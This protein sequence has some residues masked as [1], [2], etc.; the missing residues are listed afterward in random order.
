[1]EQLTLRDLTGYWEFHNRTEN[2]SADTVR[3]CNDALATLE[4]YLVGAGMSTLIA[5]IGEPE[6]R[7]FIAHMQ[8]QHCWEGLEG[9][10]SERLL[11][12][13]SI[14]TRVRALKAFFAWLHREDYTESHRLGRL[15]NYKTPK[16]VVEVLTEAEIGRLLKACDP[17]TAWGARGHAIVTLALDSGLRLSEITGLRTADLNL[18]PAG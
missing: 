11:A 17:K 7:G 3:W 1:M 14:Q 5:D 16:Q 15:P 4:R 6:V 10:E 13:E 12:A 2:K 9:R 8:Q 18:R